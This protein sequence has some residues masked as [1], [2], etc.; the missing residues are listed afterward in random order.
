M[1]DELTHVKPVCKN[2]IKKPHERLM[3]NVVGHTD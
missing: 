3:L 2:S 1:D